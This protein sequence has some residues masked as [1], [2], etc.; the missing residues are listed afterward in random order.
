MLDQVTPITDVK[1]QDS[2]ARGVT[3]VDFWAP[4]CGPCRMLG[5]VLDEVVSEFTGKVNLIKINV[6]DNQALAERFGIASI[7]TI[8]IFKDGKMV[9]K[10]V[11]GQSKL[12]LKQL[13]ASTLL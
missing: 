4:W 1:F 11:G 3:V 7:P 8:L 2:V 13:I 6:D 10:K 5:P 9:D 12:Q